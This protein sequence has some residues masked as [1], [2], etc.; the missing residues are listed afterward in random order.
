MIDLR[1]HTALV[2]G[3]TQGVGQAIALSLAE[4]GANVIVHGLEPTEEA[5]ETVKRCEAYG[6]QAWLICA[7][8]AGPTSE[9]VKTLF[10]LARDVTDDIDILV[11]NAGGYF[12]RPFLEMDYDTF[13]QTMRL[14]V[15][16]YYFLAQQFARHWVREGVH[17]RILMTGSINGRLAEPVHSAYDTS[18]GAVE[19]MVKTLSVELAPHGI[20]VNGVA[21]GLFHTP[22]TAAAL[23][24]PRVMRWMQLH[25]PNGLVPGADVCGDAA[26]YLVS[27]AAKH[28]H[29]HMLMVDGGMSIWQQPDVPSDFLKETK[30]N[31]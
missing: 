2:T 25:T 24:D 9:C 21:P 7:D 14:N 12:D 28:V 3:S 8:L 13:E 10:Q 18:K 26:A 15:Y 20:R 29:G 23:D 1:G 4:S 17:G 31:V 16:A 19:M 22:L 27:D 6:R 11:N 30:Q 5:R